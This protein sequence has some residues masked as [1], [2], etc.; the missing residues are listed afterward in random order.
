MATATYVVR[1]KWDDEAG[2]WYAYSDDVP[3]LATGADTLDDLMRK[4]EVV[5]PEML[6]ANGII[7]ASEEDVEIPFI[8]LTDGIGHTRRAA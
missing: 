3:G 4:L 8:V 7:S 6:E 2:V 1:C 5:V